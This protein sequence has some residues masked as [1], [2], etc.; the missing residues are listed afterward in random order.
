MHYL[1]LLFLFWS[2]IIMVLICWIRV[3]DLWLSREYL[4]LFHVLFLFF[5]RIFIRFFFVM[6]FR[7]YGS[8]LGLF[9]I[10]IFLFSFWVSFWCF[11]L[12]PILL[13]F[14]LVHVISIIRLSFLQIE[15]ISILS[16][17]N[18][19]ILSAKL[20]LINYPHHQ[21]ILYHPQTQNSSYNILTFI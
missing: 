2:L 4:F 17:F 14:F 10:P 9:F 20:I 3:W 15:F 7:R 8:D 21:I 1:D 19:F 5:R 13:I 6:E 12:D 11:C 16:F 18:L